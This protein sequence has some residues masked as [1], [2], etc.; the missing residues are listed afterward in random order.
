MPVTSYDRGY[1]EGTEAVVLTTLEERFGTLPEAVRTR[2]ESMG[3]DEL[4]DLARRL[5]HAQS[6]DELDLL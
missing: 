3:P 2:V 5:V 4:L 1:A 6:L